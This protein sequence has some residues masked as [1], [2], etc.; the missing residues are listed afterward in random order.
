MYH[1]IIH[2]YNLVEQFEEE[3]NHNLFHH[4]QVKDTQLK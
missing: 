1:F 2:E 3:H 4:F